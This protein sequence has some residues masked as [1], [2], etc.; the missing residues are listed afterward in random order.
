MNEYDVVV[1]VVHLNNKVHF[2][3]QNNT[4]RAY[5]CREYHVPYASYH[6]LSHSF[7]MQT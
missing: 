3:S 4:S 7:Q 1:V 2:Q 6:E 5:S